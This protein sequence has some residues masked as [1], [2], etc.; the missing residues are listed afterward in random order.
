MEVKPFS[1]WKSDKAPANGFSWFNTKTI[2]GL[3]RIGHTGSQGGFRA[4]FE[5]VPEKNLLVCM[6]FNT[7]YPLTKLT[8]DIEKILVEEKIL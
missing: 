4:D 8:T 1:N 5:M 2:N 6:L 7:P 3:K